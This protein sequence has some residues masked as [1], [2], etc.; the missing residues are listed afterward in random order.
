MR[1]PKS[2]S[3]ELLEKRKIF[4]N[5]LILAFSFLILGII[6]IHLVV[7]RTKKL[8]FIK[9]L[10]N[11]KKKVSIQQA[12]ARNRYI[13]NSELSQIEKKAKEELGMSYPNEVKYFK[14]K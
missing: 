3:R 9:D 11:E 4:R 13:K 10:E 1:N 14:L 5:F 12:E 8:L 2:D 6:Y 7:S